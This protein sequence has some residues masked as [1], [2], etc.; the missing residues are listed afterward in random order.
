MV[1]SITIAIAIDK[2][3]EVIEYRNWE[4]FR[5]AILS[6]PAMLFHKIACAVSSCPELNRMTLLHATLKFD[7]PVDVI[8]EMIRICPDM[9]AARDC[10][11]RTPLHV[12]AGSKASASLIKLLANACL[13]VCDV[14]DEGGKTPL[15]FLCDS[16]SVM[17]EEVSDE[18]DAPRQPPNHEAVAAV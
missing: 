11:G 16:Y 1:D 5:D 7:P 17:F 14:Q 8:V 15:H 2:T 4:T 9:L 18:S 10:L 12:A 3:L 13:E 6:R